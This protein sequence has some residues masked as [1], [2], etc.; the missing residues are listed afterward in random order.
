MVDY[1]SGHPYQV[2]LPYPIDLRQG[3]VTHFDPWEESGR[4]V[5]SEQKLGS[6]A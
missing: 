2:S 3:H 1:F 4:D 5:L 6:S